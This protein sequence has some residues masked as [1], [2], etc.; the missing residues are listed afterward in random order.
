[1]KLYGRDLIKALSDVYAPLGSEEMA[2]ELIKEQI[3]DDA[4][5]EIDRVGN[6]IAKICGGDQSKRTMICANMDE[7]G[8]IVRD[9]DGEGRV[10]PRFFG[11]V[12]TERISGRLGVINGDIRCIFSAKPIHFVSGSERT[13]PTPADRIYAE[14]GLS[15]KEKA[16]E[17]VSL[18]DMGAFYPSFSEIGRYIKGKALGSRSACY[19]LIEMIRKIKNDNIA[20][21]G[22]VYFVFATR[23]CIGGMGANVAANVIAPTRALMIDATK[24]FDTHGVSDKDVLTR[25]GGGAAILAC[26][27]RSIFDGDMCASAIEYAKNNDVKYQYVALSTNDGVGQA[28]QRALG[29]CKCGAIS[30]PTRH[31]KSASEMVS[32][33]DISAVIEIA[34]S[35]V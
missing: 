27:G 31:H 32:E 19:V 24:A 25:L 3:G 20:L 35:L 14:A 5:V 1:M 29:G 22:D 2:A 17:R 16:E 34:L 18:G 8:F 4:I 23:G 6:V 11:G 26:D 13:A 10:W 33:A 12:P 15:N 21:S 30:I 28:V 7:P 9:I